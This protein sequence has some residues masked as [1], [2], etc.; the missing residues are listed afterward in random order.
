ME[1]KQLFTRYKH[2]IFYLFFGVCTT[3]VNVIVYW[4][5]VHVFHMPVMAGT[6]L[7]WLLAVLFAYTSNRKWVFH[8]EAMGVS[9]IWKELISFFACRL[10]TGFVDWICMFIFV[11]IMDLNDVLIKFLANI[12]V[13]VL[14][15]VASKLII[16]KKKGEK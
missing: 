4:I 12:V 7:A 13:I 16:F 8:S 9:E 14:N 15:Y 1:I 6:I 10:A 3:A 2:V 5:A 11:D